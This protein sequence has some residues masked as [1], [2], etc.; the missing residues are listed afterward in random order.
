MRGRRR[1]RETAFTLIELV[2]VIVILGIL[3]TVALPAYLSYKVDAA[4]A[5]DKAVI[6]NIKD[7]ANRL[8][9]KTIAASGGTNTSWPSPA[10][11]LANITDPPM[12][13]GYSTNPEWCYTTST[14]FI[15][16]WC[17]HTDVSSRRIWLC[18]TQDLST[19]YKAGTWL[20]LGSA[21]K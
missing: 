12:H 17:P 21:H 18:F 2:T 4:N 3:A 20:S 9:L 15:I 16:F 5:I 13:N 10:T 8:R 19:F 1:R 14:W 6:A 11:L 7:T